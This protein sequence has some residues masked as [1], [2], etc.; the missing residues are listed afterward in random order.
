TP[1]QTPPPQARARHSHPD[2]EPATATRTATRTGRPHRDH[3]ATAGQTRPAQD[4]LGFV[5]VHVGRAVLVLFLTGLTLG[6][7]SRE[8][9]VS[10]PH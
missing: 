3:T 5:I 1:S 10:L 8:Q 4:Y 9:P 7:R 2:L 6:R